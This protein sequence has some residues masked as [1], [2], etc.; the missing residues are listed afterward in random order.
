[1]FG[2]ELADG[3]GLVAAAGVALAGGTLAAA[4]GL[5]RRGGPGAAAGAVFYQAYA[6][7]AAGGTCAVFVVS[8][9]G[10]RYLDVIDPHPWGHFSRYFT[11]PLAAGLLAGPVWAAATRLSPARWVRAA[12]LVVPAGAAG[13]LL[14]PSTTTPRPPAL[15]LLDPYPE[16]VKAV[17]AVCRPRGLTDG[18]GGYWEAKPVTR[19]SRAGV[20]VHPVETDPAAAHRVRP[21][22]W[23]DTAAAYWPPPGDGPADPY[24]FVLAA[25]GLPADAV[26]L[27]IP[28]AAAVAAFGP[29]AEAVPVGRFR[30]LVYNRPA[31]AGLARFADADHGALVWKHRAAPG[32]VTRFPGAGF[33]RPTGAAV[34]GTGLVA[35]EGVTPA[36]YMAAGPDLAPAAAGPLTVTFRVRAAGVPAADATVDVYAT[37]PA[38]GVGRLVAVAPVPPDAAGDIKF[39]FDV[40]RQMLGERLQFRTHY[41][42]RGRLAVEWVDVAAGR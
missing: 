36:G 16:F 3:N 34:E 23:L 22:V 35:A 32:R 19:L 38:T 30:L 2:V 20:R 21:F 18:L 13:W 9:T 41:P 8:L 1:M 42:G 37:D 40:T 39:G 4:G 27:D 15:D 17:D 24:Q 12:G 31:D 6:V 28:E 33:R 5:V 14:V 7:A 25:P 26:G 10:R 11:G 29:P